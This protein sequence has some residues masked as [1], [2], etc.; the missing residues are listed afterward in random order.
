[1]TVLLE[2]VK[3]LPSGLCLTVCSLPH[4]H[5]TPDF[6]CWC[7]WAATDNKVGIQIGLAENC[8]YCICTSGQPGAFSWQLPFQAEGSKWVRLL[9]FCQSFLVLLWRTGLPVRCQCLMCYTDQTKIL[10]RES[11]LIGALLFLFLGSFVCFALLWFSF[12]L[13]F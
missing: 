13:C 1:M 3:D 11:V 2:C 10:H 6:W 8:K 4:T 12:W 5:A 9:Y 7:L